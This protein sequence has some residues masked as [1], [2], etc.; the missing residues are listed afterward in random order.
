MIC[1]SSFVPVPTL[2]PHLMQNASYWTY[3]Y[4]LLAEQ[5]FYSMRSEWS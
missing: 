2:F 4:M 5:L 3:K 1:I